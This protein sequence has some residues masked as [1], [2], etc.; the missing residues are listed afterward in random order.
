MVGTNTTLHLHEGTA[1][2]SADTLVTALSGYVS[3][4]LSSLCE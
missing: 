3:C 2:I 4:L 1:M